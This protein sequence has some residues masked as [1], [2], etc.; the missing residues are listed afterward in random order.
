ML[1]IGLL[2]ALAAAIFAAVLLVEDWGG[3]TFT[4]NGF[5]HVLGHLTLAEIFLSGI[6]LSAI[7]FLA[8]WAAGLSGSMRRRASERRRAENRAVREE[9]EQLLLERD[10][11]ARDLESERAARQAAGEALANPPVVEHGAVADAPVYPRESDVYGSRAAYGDP[12]YAEAP[13]TDGEVP[14]HTV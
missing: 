2:I 6:V 14:R 3:A 10:R 8:L 13:V 1:L 12:R 9:R 11:L 5:G 7:F 4:V